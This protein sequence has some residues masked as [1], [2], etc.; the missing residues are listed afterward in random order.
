MLGNI[1]LPFLI[2]YGTVI[3][4]LVSNTYF[5]NEIALLLEHF[6]G[7]EQKETILCVESVPGPF[8]SLCYCR[9]FISHLRFS[10]G[11]GSE[12]CGGN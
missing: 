12:D 4:A 3:D 9:F 11:F 2:P 7:L 6:S 1:C 10:K 8:F 5:F